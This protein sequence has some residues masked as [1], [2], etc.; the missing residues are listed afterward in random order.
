MGRMGCILHL[1]KKAI[2]FKFLHIFA[3]PSWRKTLSNVGK[4]F[5]GISPLHKHTMFW[6]MYFNVFRVGLM[7]FKGI[8]TCTT[9]DNSAVLSYL[10]MAAMAKYEFCLISSKVNVIF[11]RPIIKTKIY[12]V[13]CTLCWLRVVM[14]GVAL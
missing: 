10:L 12:L 7:N 9:L 5:C 3:I 1:A 13:I 2:D 8:S 14:C 6:P 4:T 11:S